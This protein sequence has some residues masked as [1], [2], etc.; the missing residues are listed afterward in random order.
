[1]NEQI[2]YD[3]PLFPAQLNMSHPLTRGLVGCWVMNEN[4]PNSMRVWDSSPYKNHGVVT[5][6]QGR[7][8]GR[9]FVGAG[10]F[11]SIPDHDLWDS[12]DFTL[13]IWT[14]QSA[15]AGN[16]WQRAFIAHNTTGGTANKWTFAHDG[17]ATRLDWINTW[18]TAPNITSDAWT[19]SAGVWYC[20]GLT[21]IGNAFTFYKDGVANGTATE[22]TA[23]PN[24]AQPLTIG[25]AEGSPKT[26]DGIIS[27]ALF[28]KL[29]NSA[30]AMKDLYLHPCDMFLR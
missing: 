17:T 29:G 25:W 21:R 15:F 28:Y 6:A 14:K 7:W 18:P 4:S 3:R 12:A 5:G 26:Y 22:S 1:M 27:L 24:I 19:L 8:Q 23:L 2:L 30:M 16:Y 11:I 13:S 9:R 10:D 20:I